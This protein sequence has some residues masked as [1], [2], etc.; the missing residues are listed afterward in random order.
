MSGASFRTDY[1]N[2]F[3]ELFC[4]NLATLHTDSS[5]LA[6]KRTQS[7]EKCKCD[8]GEAHLQQ[9]IAQ[10]KLRL[11][12]DWPSF[13]VDKEHPGRIDYMFFAEGEIVATCQLKGPL[14][15][16]AEDKI[17]N[18]LGDI[19]EDIAKQRKNAEQSGDIEHYVG[20]LFC[21]DKV[22]APRSVA[23]VWL[24]A[25]QADTTASLSLAATRHTKL[26]NG[27]TVTACILN[28]K[29]RTTT[30]AGVRSSSGTPPSLSPSSPPRMPF[31]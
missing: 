3:A 15:A 26:R 30:H 24:P 20:I 29:L 13:K 16:K 6:A 5:F 1:A 21:L 19:L 4:N 31:G 10:R 11:P 12:D 18:H 27:H 23:Q 7:R 28:V 17:D 8:F 14:R 25:L 22:R 2:L 9:L